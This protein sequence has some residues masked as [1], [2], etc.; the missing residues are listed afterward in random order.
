MSILK[1][2]LV[3]HKAKP[4]NLSDNLKLGLKYVKEAK[5]KGNEELLEFSF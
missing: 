3:Q 5:E 2:A 4:N 1:V